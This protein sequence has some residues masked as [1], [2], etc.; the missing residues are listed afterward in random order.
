LSEAVDALFRAD[1]AQ[2]GDASPADGMYV[3]A[4][5]GRGGH[6]GLIL[7][8]LSPQGRLIAFDKDPEAIAQAA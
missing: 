7:S 3:D 5:Y 1:D 6:S 8:R 4:T 2:P